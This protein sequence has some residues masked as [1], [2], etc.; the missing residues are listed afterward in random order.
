MDSSKHQSW[1]YGKFQEY[2]VFLE[3][4]F[5]ENQKNSNSNKDKPY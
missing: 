3:K 5:L 4:S 1:M 2:I